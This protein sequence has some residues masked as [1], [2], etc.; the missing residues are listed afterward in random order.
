MHVY[1][2]NGMLTHFQGAESPPFVRAMSYVAAGQI[3]ECGRRLT[4]LGCVGRGAQICRIGA[5]GGRSGW[6]IGAT[7]DR[8]G[9][10]AGDP[11]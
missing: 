4:I 10:R 6:R 2:L 1:A 3:A 11:G 7:Y 8:A 5:S 9:Q